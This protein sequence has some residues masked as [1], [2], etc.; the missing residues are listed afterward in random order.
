MDLRVQIVIARMMDDLKR[1]LRLG[2]MAR[3]VNLSPSRLQHLFK[4]HTSMT[5]A[6]YLK[7]LRM[8]HAKGLVESTLLTVKEIRAGVG[9]KDESHFVRDFKKAYGLS[10]RKY[11]M[12]HATSH[13][14]PG[15]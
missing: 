8:R 7:S 6:Q 4:A 3:S 14:D 1:P 9:I 11:R 12:N 15:S 10:P 2:V 13:T 5:P